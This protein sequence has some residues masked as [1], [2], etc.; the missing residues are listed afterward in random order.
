MSYTDSFILT[1]DQGTSGTKSLVFSEHGE[2]IARGS[3][4]LNSQY[5]QPGFVEQEP[6]EIF[7]TV[8]TSV[9]EC[10]ETFKNKGHSLSSI[11]TC[12]IT[13][14]RETFLLWDEDGEPLSPAVVWQCKRSVEVCKQLKRNGWETEI[15]RRTGLPV[16]PY[17]SGTKLSWILENVEAVRDKIKEGK[18][19]FG[20]IDTWLLYRLTNGKQYLTDYT[21][22]SRTMLFNIRN[23]EWDA[24]LLDMFG[25]ESLVLPEVAPSCFDFGETDF[26]GLLDHLVPI[27]AMMG[28]SHAAAFGERCYSRG[29]AKATLG[30][31]CSIMMNTGDELY[32]SV[33]GLIGTICWSTGDRIAYGLE[34]AIVSCG[35]TLEWLKNQLGLFKE[36]T[37]IMKMAQQ[38]ESSEGVCVIPAFSGVG[39][40][41]WDMEAR[42]VIA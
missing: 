6:E 41:Y 26:A 14:Q 27:S 42:G 25:L 40:P 24:K 3:A 20:T 39:A 38:V 1:V 36:N 12:G 35:S 28:D 23:L 2:F 4:S 18:A 11:K 16:D 19:H 33:D 15:K 37:E 13:N 7:Q 10:L 30:T 17:Y 9:G 21:N 8:L 31:G 34:G 5:P 29:T 22:A 32:P